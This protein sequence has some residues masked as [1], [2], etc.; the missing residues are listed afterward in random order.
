[1]Y[2][3]KLA[4]TFDSADTP[5][6][7]FGMFNPCYIQTAR[8][9]NIS[10]QTP[11]EECCRKREEGGSMGGEGG[12][13]WAASVQCKYTCHWSNMSACFGE[14]RRPGVSEY[15]IHRIHRYSSTWWDQL[16]L[17]GT[18][19]FCVCTL[20]L[21]EHHTHATDVTCECVFQKGASFTQRLMLHVFAKTHFYAIN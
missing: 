13:R 2:F 5:T 17:S 19:P 7:W 9:S 12:V 11:S 20:L 6:F 8:C 14:R 10:V 21:G 15:T 1:M 16:C 18:L 3:W 4:F